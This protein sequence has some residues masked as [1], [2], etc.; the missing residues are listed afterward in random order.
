MKHNILFIVTDD[1]K[2]QTIHAIDNPDIITP[3]LDKLVTSGSYF[4]NAYIPGGYVGAVCMPSRA[5]INSGRNLCELWG[6]GEKIPEEHITLAESLRNNGYYTYG[7]GKWHNGTEAFTRGFCSGDN[8]FFGGMW[9]HWNVPVCDYDPT[10]KY[11]NEIDF[12]MDFHTSK[13]PSGVPSRVHCDKFNPGVH[14]TQ[15]VTNTVVDFINSYEDSKP[16]YVYSAYLAP[17]DPRTMPQKYLDLY[18]MDKLNLPPNVCD[19][20]FEYGV[21]TARDEQL[22]DLPRNEKAIRKELRSY[23]AMITHLDDEIGRIITALKEKGEYDNTIIVLCGDNGLAV[24]Q[25]GLMGKQSC[26]EHSLKIPLLVA[27]PNIPKQRVQQNVF[28][29]DIYPTLMDICGFETPDSVTSKSF[30]KAL[31]GEEFKGRE[32]M[33][34][35]FKDLVR[36]YRDGDYKIIEFANVTRRTMLFNIKNDP[37]ETCD[38]SENAEY[39]EMLVQMREKLIANS[40][41]YENEDN[42]MAKNYWDAYNLA[43]QKCL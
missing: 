4:D 43:D 5:M 1:Q 23:Y 30:Y 14:S 10:G 6:N 2:Y 3:N 12:V 36:S 20:H 24:G 40:K 26:Y 21:S 19:N 35:L 13:T 38:L 33:Y 25:H 8:I 28:L 41:I 18:D 27:G 9:D 7:T 16:F 15:M 32:Q 39:K 34:G 37:Y 42:F 29:M 11:D 31:I 22:G 17:H